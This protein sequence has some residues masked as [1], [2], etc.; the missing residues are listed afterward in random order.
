MKVGEGVGGG[1]GKDKKKKYGLLSKR[2]VK[3]AGYR[4]ST[5]LCVYESRRSRC[6]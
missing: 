1:G 6:P 3:I 4:L 2:Y 5:F